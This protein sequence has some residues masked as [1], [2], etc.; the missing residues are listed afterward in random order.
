MSRV[1]ISIACISIC[2]Y[3]RVMFLIMFFY[4]V[5][6]Y[7]LNTT[8]LATNMKHKGQAKKCNSYTITIYTSADDL[9]IVS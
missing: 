6:F 4:S 8:T 1:P 3:H 5:A 9:T 2:F 7:A